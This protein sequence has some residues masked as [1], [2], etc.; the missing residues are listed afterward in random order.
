MEIF[1]QHP[2]KHLL[3]SAILGAFAI[4]KYVTLH[5]HDSK[6]LIQA[7]YH[8][9]NLPPAEADSAINVIHHLDGQYYP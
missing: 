7:V 1:R 9:P 4:H 2:L 8:P 5:E 3:Y 6:S